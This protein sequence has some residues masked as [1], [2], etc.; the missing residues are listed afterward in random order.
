MTCNVT[1]ILYAPDG[2]VCAN[3]VVT[4]TRKGTVEAVIDGG[5]TKAIIPKTITA[6]TD[7]TG[8]IDVDLFAGPY[9]GYTSRDN[10]RDGWTFLVGVPQDAS[11][12]IGD[13]I[14][15]AADYSGI[16]NEVTAAATAAAD[17]AALSAEWAEGTEPGGAG[18]K[19]AK[20][21]ALDAKTYS[22]ALGGAAELQALASDAQDAEAGA[23]AAQGAAET[24]RDA[25]FVNADVYADIATGRA[26]VADGEQFQVVSGDE[27]V[28]YRRDSSTTQTEMARYPAA[29]R[30]SALPNLERGAGY[31]YTANKIVEGSGSVYADVYQNMGAIV[32]GDSYEL[33]AIVKAAERKFCRLYVNVNARMDVFF[34]L[35]KGTVHNQIWGTGAI[36]YLGGGRYECRVSAVGTVANSA[37]A[38]LMASLDG[39]A[40]PYA[41]DGASGI[42]VE[43]FRALHNGVDLWST[44]DISDASFTK[45]GSSVASETTGGSLFT[46]E[47]AQ[48]KRTVNGKDSLFTGMKWAALGTSITDQN[49]YV[50]SLTTLLGTTTQNLGVSGGSL[51][52]GSDPGA[53]AVYNEI[54]NIDSDTD[55][56][57]IEAGTNDFGKRNSTLGSLGYTTTAT[58]YGALYAAV[59]AIQSQAPN[60]KIVFLTP[61]SADSRFP[62]WSITTT[63]AD[64]NG[65][66]DFQQAVRDVANYLGFPCIDVGGEGGF[67]Y[68][69]NGPI[70][71]DGL[72]PN[73]LGGQVFAYYVYTMLQLLAK[74]WGWA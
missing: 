34:D 17:S 11:A 36:T 43:S 42:I 72:H 13:I 65:F 22:D 23:V 48:L 71:V 16:A 51:A 14:S 2:T 49:K 37:N 70:T 74:A 47:F 20:E 10:G 24:A 61:Y 15:Q 25:A 62:N 53:L 64:G 67:G 29:S 55:L 27:I 60:A 12:L 52:D 59:V 19:S 1:G 6:M 39:S 3:Q 26:A 33:V 21:H 68:L 69:T 5:A 4:F 58:F 73:D 50:S 46:E 9:D 41:G 35:D 57:T 18:T 30:L 28:R 66:I 38:Q 63:D 45:L 54:P 8:A 31:S 40:P 32:I 56:V 7:G 44:D